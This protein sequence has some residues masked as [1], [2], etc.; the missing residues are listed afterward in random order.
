[1]KDIR[2]VFFGVGLVL[3]TQ[4]GIFSLNAWAKDS[5]WAWSKAQDQHVMGDMV[6]SDRVKNQHYFGFGA[7]LGR[8]RYPRARMTVRS[9]FSQYCPQAPQDS[10]FPD[11]FILIQ[12]NF[13]KETA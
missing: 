11:Y 2:N 12:K 3:G 5:P 6:F 7:E 13:V 1:M 4:E 8:D 10:F 9:G